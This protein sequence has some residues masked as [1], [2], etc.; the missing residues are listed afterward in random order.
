M[1]KGIHIG[2]AVK[3]LIIKV[4]PAII[5]MII[6]VIILIVSMYVLHLNM[7]N[8]YSVT[9]IIN[10]VGAGASLANFF[11]PKEDNEDE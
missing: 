11:E 10:A 3:R 2:K 1:N 4:F 9:R 5:A 6:T 7:E 8:V